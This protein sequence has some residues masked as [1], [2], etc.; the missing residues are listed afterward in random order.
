MRECFERRKKEVKKRLEA[1]HLKVI[2]EVETV[3]GSTNSGPTAS[4]KVPT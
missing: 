4:T 1:F 3:K 2:T